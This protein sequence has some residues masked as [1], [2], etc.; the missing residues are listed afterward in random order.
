MAMSV[1]VK[2]HSG[3]GMQYWADAIKKYC[4]NLKVKSS[5]A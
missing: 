4:L 1:A 2:K 3:C 5:V